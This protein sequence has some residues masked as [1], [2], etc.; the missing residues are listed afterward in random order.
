[1]LIQS[2]YSTLYTYLLIRRH[3]NFFRFIRKQYSCSGVVENQFASWPSML[4]V[5]VFRVNLLAWSRELSRTK[6]SFRSPR[7]SL[8]NFSVV[9]NVRNFRV[10]FE[11]SSIFLVY[12]GGPLSLELYSRRLNH[13]ENFLHSAKI[14]FKETLLTFQ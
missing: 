1:M 13:M 8:V 5:L 6:V 3:Q 12:F 11:Q 4:I 10:Q 2:V 9:D 14:C 7:K